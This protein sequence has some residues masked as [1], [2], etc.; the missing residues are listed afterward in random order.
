MKGGTRVSTL[1]QV[2]GEGPL[3]P[4]RV[5]SEGWAPGGRPGPPPKLLL[6]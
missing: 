5:R 4:T 2:G 1:G 6:C 3:H